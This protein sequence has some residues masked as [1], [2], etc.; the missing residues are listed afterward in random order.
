MLK[1]FSS[2]AEKARFEIF[3]DAILAIIITILVLEFKV[4]ERTFGS[5]TDIKSFVYNLLPSVFSYVISFVTI[6]SLWINH[7]DL[8][9]KIKNVDSKFVLLNF[10]FI[11][12]LAPLPFTTALAGRNHRSSFAVMLVASNYFLMNLGFSFIWAYAISKK[13]VP[14]HELSKKYQKRNAN[15]S[16]IAGILLLLSIPAAFINTYISF[17]IFII[18]LAL[19]IGKEFFY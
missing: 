4:P 19:H 11:L 9:R 10:L 3:I 6:A 7:H 8:C 12:F 16:M 13:M 2:E 1:H 18:V 14:E 15:I 17:N 5:D